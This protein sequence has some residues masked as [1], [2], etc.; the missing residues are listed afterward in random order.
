MDVSR[1]KNTGR[2]I[3][4]DKVP[5]I[6]DQVGCRAIDRSLHIAVA[7]VGIID[8]DDFLPRLVEPAIHDIPLPVVPP[9]AAARKGRGNTAHVAARGGALEPQRNLAHASPNLDVGDRPMQVAGEHIESVDPGTIVRAPRI[10]L[11]IARTAIIALL[12]R[13]ALGL[14]GRRSWIAA[15][16]VGQSR[17]RAAEGEQ[18]RRGGYKASGVCFHGTQGVGV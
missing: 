17:C 1:G 11:V 9:V 14:F 3:F 8:V 18:K 15:G 12:P 7:A 10:A 5:T 2:I 4:G 16:I 6:V 13:G